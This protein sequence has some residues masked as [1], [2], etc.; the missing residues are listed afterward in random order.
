M[1]LGMAESIVLLFIALLSIIILLRI[2]VVVHHQTNKVKELEMRL[3][4]MDN[5]EVETPTDTN[6]ST[7]NT[8]K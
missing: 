6:D 8:E 7:Y 5:M 4:A 2:L 1:T 3:K